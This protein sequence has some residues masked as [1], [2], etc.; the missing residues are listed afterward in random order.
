M[1]TETRP[2]HR[3]KI[4]F[5]YKGKHWITLYFCTLQFHHA[6]RF[7]FRVFRSENF[8]WSQDTRSNYATP[9]CALCT[10]SWRSALSDLTLR[11]SVS[12][13][14]VSSSWRRNKDT[15]TLCVSSID[16]QGVSKIKRR[17]ENCLQ[18]PIV[19]KWQRLFQKKGFTIQI[20]F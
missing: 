5:F 8:S 20:S 3:R 6:T 14:L 10:D 1:F 15:F 7:R 16:L 19:D 9:G 12:A 2:V 13:Q 17:L 11:L 18:F 4:D